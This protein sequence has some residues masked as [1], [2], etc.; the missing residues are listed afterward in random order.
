MKIEKKYTWNKFIEINQHTYKC[1]EL[2]NIVNPLL[3][4]KVD[5]LDIKGDRQ[6][7][8]F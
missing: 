8:L 6:L 3:L 4:Y 7:M 5:G 1:A 2:D